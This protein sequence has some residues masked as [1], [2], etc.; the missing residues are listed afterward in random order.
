MRGCHDDIVESWWGLSSRVDKH[1]K[2]VLLKPDK[3]YWTT[4][5]ARIIA[6]IKWTESG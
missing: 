5:P 1:N 6:N 2:T 4:V 3:K